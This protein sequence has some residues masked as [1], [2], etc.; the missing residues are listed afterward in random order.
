MHEVQRVATQGINL[1]RVL[2]I[3]LAPVLPRM[4]VAGRRASSARPS[5]TG[6]QL[7][8]PLLI[9]ALSPYQPLATAPD[10][11]VVR[12]SLVA[13]RHRGAAAVN[14]PQ[15]NP[16]QHRHFTS[17]TCASRG[18]RGQ[19]VEGSDKL[20]QLTLDLGQGAA[21]RLLRHPRQL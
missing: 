10:P 19:R 16:D 15:A 14:C 3:Y 12:S 11:A 20:L 6:T 2:M 13:R 5:A 18:P 4:A 21:Q 17:S 8:A 9:G 1:F 7:R